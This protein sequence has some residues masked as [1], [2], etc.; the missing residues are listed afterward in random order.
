MDYSPEIEAK[1]RRLSAHPKYNG[2]KADVFSIG[3][4]IFMVRMQ[5][6]PFAKAT[7]QDPYF[8]RLQ[9]SMK[10]AYWKIFKSV[11]YPSAFREL[12]EKILTKMPSQRFGLEQIRSSKYLDDSGLLGAAAAKK[13][14]ELSSDDS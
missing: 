3:A 11:K 9:G 7:M 12:M 5:S 4:T 1:L 8:K 14:N 13:G 2:E 6:P 10:Q